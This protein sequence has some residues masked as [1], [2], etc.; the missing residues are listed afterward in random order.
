MLSDVTYEIE[1]VAI[2]HSHIG[3]AQV[4]GFLREE[5]ARLNDAVG[6]VDVKTHANQ[7][8]FEKFANVFLVIDDQNARDAIVRPAAPRRGS[9]I[10]SASHGVPSGA[11]NRHRQ[12][13]RR[14]GRTRPER[15]PGSPDWLRPTRVQCIAPV[16]CLATPW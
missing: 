4:V 3:Q 11:E 9:G 12:I 6:L 15:I 10:R 14:Q 5:R 8:E 16:P 7:R 1:P 13:R 2:A